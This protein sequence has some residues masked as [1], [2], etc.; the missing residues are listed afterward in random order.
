MNIFKP[1]RFFCFLWVIVIFFLINPVLF[2]RSYLLDRT[3]IIVNQE[4]ITQNELSLI[5][6]Q[7]ETETNRRLA[8]KEKANLINE[9]I[10]ELLL[11]AESKQLGI[12]IKETN[13][14]QALFNFQKANQLSNQDLERL[15][16]NRGQNIRYFRKEIKKKQIGEI[17]LRRLHTAIDVSDEEIA[18]LYQEKYP[19]QT[20]YHLKLLLKK[21]NPKELS[22]IRKIATQNNNFNELILK[23]SDDPFVQ[24]NKGELPPTTIEDMIVEFAE[25][26]TTL[27]VNEISEP[28]KTTG[29]YYLIQLVQKSETSEIKLESVKSLL[30]EEVYKKKYKPT[31]DSYTK[32]LRRKYSV[33]IKDPK[34]LQLLEKFGYEFL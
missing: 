3:S 5:F 30:K 16:R 17:M 4:T 19:T 8:P 34:I 26:I 13:I 7:I 33:V 22:K 28:V 2:A 31:L 6:K 25:V 1:N 11:I 14:N 27:K 21:K 23:Y 32:N 18:Q 9:L 20:F 29:G 15:L 10:L 12:S 24:Q